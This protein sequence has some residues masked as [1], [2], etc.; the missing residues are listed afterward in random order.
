MKKPVSGIENAAS[1]TLQHFGWEVL[2]KWEKPFADERKAIPRVFGEAVFIGGVEG[3][4][5]AHTK[6]LGLWCVPTLFYVVMRKY[7]MISL[8][9]AQ[10]TQGF[11]GTNGGLLYR[12]SQDMERFRRM[13]VGSVVVMGRKTWDSLPASSKPLKGRRCV[14]V[15]R[16]PELCVESAEVINDL[17]S[18][19]NDPVNYKGQDVF[20]IGGGQVFEQAL[21]FAEF[22]FV[23][24]IHDDAVG[25]VKAPELNTDTWQVVYKEDYPRSDERPAFT[26]KT[27]RRLGKKFEQV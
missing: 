14:V 27:L 7:G 6:V 12:I 23:T 3:W 5:T 21:G 24:E 11:I 22:V 2:A 15:S 9:Y 17:A 19:L 25:D 18:Y 10:N 13:T 20:V 16:D 8:I 1:R 4:S 26:F